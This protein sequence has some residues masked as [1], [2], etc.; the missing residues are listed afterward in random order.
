M[1]GVAVCVWWQKASAKQL[2]GGGSFSSSCWGWVPAYGTGSAA[3]CVMQGRESRQGLATRCNGGGGSSSSK[4]TSSHAAV[5][6]Q[7]LFWQLAA[8]ATTA[9]ATV[10][11]ADGGHKQQHAGADA[12]VSCSTH[13]SICLSVCG[14]QQ[15]HKQNRQR[16]LQEAGAWAAAA[17]PTSP[18]AAR[19]SNKLLCCN[20]Q[21]S[22]AVAVRQQQQH[23]GSI[24]VWPWCAPHTARCRSCG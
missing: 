6:A 16:P 9:T 3:G 20:A 18:A 22:I 14:K 21:C 8:L 15:Q 11:A 7:A 12:C 17:A 23:P 24:V 10:A 13:H 19:S 1:S 4:T 2:P 5:C